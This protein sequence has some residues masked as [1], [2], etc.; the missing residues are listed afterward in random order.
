MVGESVAEVGLMMVAGGVTNPRLGSLLVLD[1]ASDDFDALDGAFVGFAATESVGVLSSS[2]L[3]HRHRG[4]L[5]SQ[6]Q[7]T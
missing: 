1:G 5:V 7:Y 4:G 6:G 2:S 3:P